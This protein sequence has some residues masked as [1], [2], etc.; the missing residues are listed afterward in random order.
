LKERECTT[1]QTPTTTGATMPTSDCPHVWEFL[2]PSASGELMAWYVCRV[3]SIQEW[4]RISK[5]KA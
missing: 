1:P 3:C 4:R 2:R 5:E